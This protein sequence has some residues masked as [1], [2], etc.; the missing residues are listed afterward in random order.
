MVKLMAKGLYKWFKTKAE[1]NRFVDG[2][3]MF[4]RQFAMDDACV[5]LGRMGFTEEQF[6][7]FQQ[8]YSAV[9]TEN[10]EEVIEDAKD[11]KKDLWYSTA[12]KERE[13][14]SYVGK[15]YVPREER[16]R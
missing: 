16:Y 15:H 2:V 5:A 9:A 6:G 1:Y 8:V 4:G 11:D 13:L 12:K 3:L 14:K 7:K 10:A